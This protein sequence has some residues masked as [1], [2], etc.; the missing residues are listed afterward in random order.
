[1]S[2]STD[3]VEI[4]SAGGARITSRLRSWWQAES[5]SRQFWIF[6]TA[7][8][9][10]DF[11]I[12]LYF[13]LFNLFLLSLR[14]DERMMGFVTGALTLGNVVGTI[15]VGLLARRFGLQKLLLFCF[16]VA[17][18]ISIFRTMAVVDARTD[19]S[20]IFGRYGV[21]LL[22]GLLCA[23]GCQSDNREQSRLRIQ[24]RL[25]Y[26]HRD[27][28]ACRRGRWFTT[29]N[30]FAYPWSSPPWRWNSTCPHWCFAS[31]L[32]RHLACFAAEVGSP[33]KS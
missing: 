30:A 9:F 4:P 31:C 26:G 15:P 8:F 13:F 12:G 22:A 32:P 6:F 23:C 5:L 14:F 2:S 28:N 21:E 19:R 17:P 7:A 11:G 33:R 16:I 18:I 3:C 1:M 25:C 29:A 27:R 24:H 20:R 10:F